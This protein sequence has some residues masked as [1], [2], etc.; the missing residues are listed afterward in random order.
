[1]KLTTVTLEEEQRQALLLAMAHL[2]L[3]RPGWDDLL[4]RIAL[5]MDNVIQ[6]GSTDR[7]Q[8]YDEFRRAFSQIS[9]RGGR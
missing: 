3:A 6:V 8:L 5:K 7:A 1:M 9:N 4:N 2:S